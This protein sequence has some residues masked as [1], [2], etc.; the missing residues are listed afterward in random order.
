MAFIRIDPLQVDPTAVHGG[1]G[2]DGRGQEKGAGHVEGQVEAVAEG[3]VGGRHHL[4]DDVGD[5]VVLG[6]GR[7]GLA[8]VGSLPGVFAMARSALVEKR[9]RVA[10][11]RSA[12][13]RFE[14]LAYV[15]EIRSS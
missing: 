14:G 3:A 15:P 5:G 4:V 7:L 9:N 12:T 11:K 2:E 10:G 13:A 8:L 6:F 1:Q